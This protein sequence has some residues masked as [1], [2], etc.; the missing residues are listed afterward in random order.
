MKQNK[1]VVA[2]VITAVAITGSATALANA[3]GARAKSVK[4]T[5]TSVTTINRTFNVN[6]M[7]N[8]AG[9]MRG[10]GGEVTAVLSDLVTKGTLTAAESK[11]VS[12]AWAALEAAEH[13][14]GATPKVPMTPPAAGQI[15]PELIQALKDLVAKGTLTQ[16][17]ADAVAAAVKAAHDAEDAN[18]PVGGP[19]GRGH[20]EHGD[21]D[22]M[23][24][25]RD[26]DGMRGQGPAMGSTN[27]IPS[28]TTT[29]TTAN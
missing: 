3:S 13:A 14:A 11:A 19:M 12:D 27:G 8:M 2:V 28:T 22:G 29:S 25:H 1:K 5:K 26:H 21:H 16:A 20:G 4:T 6:G 15:S 24:D 23:R 7:G 9:G 10:H 17:K 18:R